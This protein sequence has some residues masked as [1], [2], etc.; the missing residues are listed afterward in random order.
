VGGRDDDHP[1][2]TQI[3][4]GCPG[5]VRVTNERKGVTVMEQFLFEMTVRGFFAMFGIVW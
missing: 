3:A 5:G 4:N 2:L 1:R